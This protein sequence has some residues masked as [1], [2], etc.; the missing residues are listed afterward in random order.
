MEK[1]IH[2]YSKDT[3]ELLS[4]KPARRSPLSKNVEYLLPS[5]A[6]FKDP[7][8]QPE[9]YINVFDNNKWK[10]VLDK[11]GTKV[12]HKETKEAHKVDTIG[13][14]LEIY[15]AE[16]PKDVEFWNGTEWETDQKKLDL[17]IYTLKER[18]YGNFM[19][20]QR[21]GGLDTNLFSLVTCLAITEK[22][23][24]KALAVKEWAD[25]LWMVYKDIKKSIDE[26]RDLETDISAPDTQT[27]PYSF[28]DILEEAG[29]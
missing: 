15:T 14:I 11:R 1:L 9:G 22:A 6:T 3:G 28:A 10:L 24:P 12:F 29:I 8:K 21:I 19:S 7:L 17:E 26:S 18:L 2:N 20:A 27:V 13:E 23:G 4:S 16:E 25:L 5:N